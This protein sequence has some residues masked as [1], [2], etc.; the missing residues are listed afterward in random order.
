MLIIWV[1]HTEVVVDVTF[2]ALLSAYQLATIKIQK[3]VKAL[4]GISLL[5]I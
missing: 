2:I 1:S 5:L 3:L 4:H